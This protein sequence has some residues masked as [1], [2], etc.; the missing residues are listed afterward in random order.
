MIIDRRY[1]RLQMTC[2]SP[3]TPRQGV[4]ECSQ[5]FALLPQLHIELDTF[6]HLVF[7]VT[8]LSVNGLAW[9]LTHYVCIRINKIGFQWGI[10]LHIKHLACSFIA[11]FVICKWGKFEQ[12][13]G[14]N[15]LHCVQYV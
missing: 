2:S 13:L 3:G 14:Q 12:I 7:L 5:L 6:M 15:S 4:L 10:Y 8:L 11:G 1:L 9:I